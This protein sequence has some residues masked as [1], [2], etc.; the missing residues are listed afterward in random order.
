MKTAIY[1]GTLFN[2]DIEENDSIFQDILTALEDFEVDRVAIVPTKNSEF[3]EIVENLKDIITSLDGLEEYVIVDTIEKDLIPPYNSYATLHA[4]KNKYC[5]DNIYI[6]CK[7][8]QLNKI[9]EW[10]NG[11]SIIEDYDFLIL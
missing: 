9:S 5:K 4:L 3:D 7:E 2:L 6:L 11:P 1:L 10:M 8:N